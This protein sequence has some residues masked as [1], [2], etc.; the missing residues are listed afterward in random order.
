MQRIGLQNAP[1]GRDH[2]KRPLSQSGRLS[3]AGFDATPA[4]VAVEHELSG[5]AQR[6]ALTAEHQP[7]AEPPD[8]SR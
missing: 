8:R 7:D 5:G 1:P 2:A 4:P 3:F 6:L